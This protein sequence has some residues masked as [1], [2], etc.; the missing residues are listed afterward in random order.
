[1]M[2]EFPSDIIL[3][4]ES[5]PNESNSLDWRYDDPMQILK[6]CGE[7]VLIANN[8]FWI[9]CTFCDER[10]H[11]ILIFQNHIKGIHIRDD[12][13]V[14]YSKIENPLD[15]NPDEESHIIK[16]E[17]NQSNDFNGRIDEPN[18]NRDK[19]EEFNFDERE[20]DL[21][22]I[23]IE[24]ERHN[25][26]D[27]SDTEETHEID[28]QSAIEN[29]NFAEKSLN[30]P[31]CKDITDPLLTKEIPKKR[32]RKKKVYS[33]PTCQHIAR[34]KKTLEAHLQ[35][36]H[37]TGT[38]H[39]CEECGKCFRNS[40]NLKCH[41][42]IHSG[43]R[44]YKCEDC[45][46]DFSHYNSLKMHRYLH[47]GERPHKCN[48]CGKGFVSS[49][50]LKTHFREHTGETPYVCEFCERAFASK[51]SFKRH[52]ISH[53]GRRAYECQ[54]CKKAFFH[55]ETL[56][57][58][59]VCHTNDKKF[60]CDICSKKFNH[61][62]NLVQHQKLHSNIKQ[63]ICKICSKEFAQYAGLYSHMKYHKD[64]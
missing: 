20:E 50:G 42:F 5:F 26:D 41:L 9:V 12:E 21:A 15:V 27:Q 56:T 64:I 23:S 54:E 24:N 16:Q 25:K 49:S 62:K 10:F 53:S 17:T 14:P 59:M 29:E 51:C 18:V 52:M 19:I 38:R 7:I 47:T 2:T 58:H 30:S 43:I 36:N 44:P 55:K 8:K 22:P 63:Y 57:K 48:V 31:I 60:A 33:C 3:K 32:N 4:N 40:N 45:D 61:K 46:A 34:D 37:G 13:I 35:S 39:Q 6:K 1:M 28:S 11:S